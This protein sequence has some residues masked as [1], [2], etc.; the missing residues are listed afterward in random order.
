MLSSQ[1]IG[2]LVRAVSSVLLLLEEKFLQDHSN[3]S[4]EDNGKVQLLEAGKADR[5]FLNLL[6]KSF[7]ENSILTTLSLI[8]L[9]ISRMLISQ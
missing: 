8:T 6:T 9:K 7:L 4:L 5:M 2:A 1:L 3:L